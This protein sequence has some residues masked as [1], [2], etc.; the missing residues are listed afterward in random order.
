MSDNNTEFTPKGEFKLF[1]KMFEDFKDEVKTS[2]TEMKKVISNALST[3]E[4]CLKLFVKEE[5]LDNKVKLI[6]QEHDRET[7]E[8]S[9]TKAHLINTVFNIG[10]KI[11]VV[12]GIVYMIITNIGV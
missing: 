3:K 8:S 9:N 1:M 12:S 2:L 7:L 6:I 11:I 10:Y 5:D 4:S